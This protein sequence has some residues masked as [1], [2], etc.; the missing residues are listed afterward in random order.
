M[1]RIMIVDDQASFCLELEEFLT[2]LGYKVVGIAY[3]GEESVDMARNIKPDL[4]L[5]DVMMPGNIDGIDA[6]KKIRE[7]L[8]IP[9]V[10]LTGY[11]EKENLE[12]AKHTRPFG[13]IVKPFEQKQI[14]SAIEIALYNADM[15]RSLRK[16]HAEL[17]MLIM[18]RTAELTRANEQINALLNG[19]SDMAL[20][21]DLEGKV[22]ASNQEAAKRFGMDLEQFL[23]KCTYDLLPPVL[24]RWRKA[25]VNRVIRTGKP[26]RF[27]EERNGL[28]YD[29][30]IYPVFD[31]EGKVFQLAIH[32]NDITKQVKAYEGLK[33]STKELKSKTSLLA[34]ANMA[35]KIM[36]QK[37]T[38]NRKE[39]EEE[40]FAN[41]RNMVVPYVLKLKSCL[42]DEEAE[43]HI[44][45]LE[46]NL[47]NIFSPFTR[48]VLPEY[49]K[50][51]PKEIQIANLIR[52]GRTTKEI[53][54]LLNVKKGT[55][56]THRD[57]IRDKLGIKKKKTNLRSYLSTLQ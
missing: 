33:E 43:G 13:Y 38:E 54:R 17:E 50:L 16:A 8:D 36:L 30:T 42:I 53:S 41:V 2:S 49:I 29:N 6:A 21:M 28:T 20:L 56:S 23:G 52:E 55:I 4:I 18:E 34:D 32:S 37:S 25:R 40:I 48:T 27:E 9:L 11:A 5:I 3:S 10:Y 35:L 1:A 7:E 47:K 19:T 15:E 12:R 24:V 51:T 14:S 22:V 57:G 44:V 26:H 46:N 31:K 45:T 39:V